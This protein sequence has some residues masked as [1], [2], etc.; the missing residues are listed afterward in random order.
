[1][2][3]DLKA[4]PAY[5]DSGVTWPGMLPTHWGVNRLGQ[6][7]SFHKGNG[8][9]REDDVES[10]VPCVRYGDVYK[11][12]NAFVVRAHSFVTEEKSVGYTHLAYG[13]LLFV[14]SGES[15]AE[16][17]KSAVNLITS[18]AVCGG[19][20]AIF[21]ANIPIDSRFLGYVADADP[22]VAQ[23]SRM[24]QGDI[25]VHTSPGKLKRLCVGLPPTDEQAAIVRYL[26]H[27]NAR[28]DR[29]I[30]A[31]RKLIALLEEQK[32][33]IIKQAVTRGLDP[34]VPLKDSGIP[35]LGEIPA[36]WP[37]WPIGRLA[38]V[39]NGSTPSRTTP[40]FWRGGNYPWLNS[41]FANRRE[42]LEADQFV[43]T[44][45]LAECHLPIVRAGSVIVAI[46]GQGKTRG[47]AALLK[48]EATINQ[49]L[50]YLTPDSRRISGSFLQS[51]LAAAYPELRRVS[52]D[53]GSTKGAL[54]C[55]DLKVFRVPAPPLLEQTQ[56][57]QWIRD[58]TQ[59][60]EAA[61]DR[62]SREIE[63]L[64][65][66]KARLT[67]DVVTGQVDVRAAAARLPELDLSDLVSDVG[68]PDEDDLDAEIAES[69]EQVDA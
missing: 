55:Q 67:A 20:L 61:A 66:F 44:R 48:M 43:T 50:A 58:E 64:R 18:R 13:D 7:G 30:A 26:G 5:K 37:V 25:V 23:K 35:W 39:G 51:V 56:I 62:A 38:R 63:L 11:F 65:E 15:L 3:T 12:H 8:G 16:I 42:V 27:A 49:H 54:T 1:M 24:G 52:E 10:G 4:Y 59:T 36:H 29:A 41:S 28:I 14:L 2:F 40:E 60:T 68:E 46:T 57:V 19:D 17:G 6:I 47:K 9:S 33:A 21:R 45:A 32:Q 34:S 53:S 31:K 22:S 69:L